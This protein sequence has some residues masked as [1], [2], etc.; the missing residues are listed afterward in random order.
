MLSP[1]AIL[2]EHYRIS[3]V[4]EERADSVIYRAI[5][6]RESFR[7]LIAALPHTNQAAIADAR[8]LATHIADVFAP[9]LLTLRDHFAQDLTYYLICD[10]PGGQDLERFLQ[11][12][13]SPLL[14]GAVLNQIE[15]LLQVLEHIHDRTPALLLG[16]LRPTDLWASP[17]GDLS[18]APFAL[19]R[20]VG[21]E[22]S[23]FRAP[24]LLDP[25]TEPTTSSDL[26]ALGAVMYR[27]LTGWAPPH[28]D[29]RQSGTP[30]TT[31]RSLNPKVSA[32]AEQLLLRVL[33]I[34]PTNRYQRAREMR[35]A[36]ETVRLMAGRPLGATAPV[37]SQASVAAALPATQPAAGTIEPANPNVLAGPPA[38]APPQPPVATATAP[39]GAT[40]PTQS[41]AP[42]SNGCLIAIVAMLAVV[43]ILICIAG[44]YVGLLI[45]NQAG[46]PLFGSAPA[47]T[48]GPA[49]PA[50]G[51]AVAPAD[52]NPPVPGTDL[53]TTFTQTA[54]IIEES[55]GATSYAPNGELL[56]VVLGSTIQL[57]DGATLDP[58]ETLRGHTGEISALAFSADSS[59]L[60]SGELDNSE[61]R[62][63]DVA[64]AS[65]VRML[66]GHSGWIRSL[67]FSNQGLLLASGS[68]DQ[69][70]RIWDVQSGQLLVVLEG[71]TD[72]IGNVAFSP[73]DE[74]LLSVARDGTARMWRTTDGEPVDTFRFVTPEDPNRDAPYWLT[75]AA[76]HP[77]GEIVAVGSTNGSVYLLDAATGSEQQ[78]LTGHTGWIVI[79]GVAFNSDGETLAS[80]GLD[81]AVRVWDPR[82]GTLLAVLERR[83]LRLI[84]LSWHPDGRRVAV[85][86]DTSGSVTVWDIPQETVLQSLQLAQGAV[87]ALTYS[88]TGEVLGSGGAGG[89]VRL[90]ALEGDR[91][92]TLSGGA[93][94][95]GYIG[96]LNN[97]ELISVSDTGAVL[98]I[99]LT[100][101]TETQP[102]TGLN[103]FALTLA[104]SQ[105]RSL[106]AAGN[107]RGDIALWETRDFELIRVLRGLDGPV[108]ALDA[109]P[110]GTRVAAV[111]NRTD[112]TSLVG[113]WDVATG[114]L[115]T[116]FD[117]HRGQ[118]T[119][120]AVPG[121]TD[122]V[123]SASSDG[124]MYIWDA[125]NGGIVHTIT[126][127]PDEGWFNAL[128]VSPD[129]TLLITG[130]LSGHLSFFDIQSGERLHR[131]ELEA[132]TILAL[133]IGPDGRH[134]AAST[135]DGGIF[136]FEAGS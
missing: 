49:Q 93:P 15:R 26:Y 31:P 81:G 10:D 115:Q 103:S 134:I 14:E 2:H 41:G 95:T 71:H 131:I 7:V 34:K 86:S 65:M 90:Q 80:V 118:I 72:Y 9:G 51:A 105:D 48:A 125:L 107:E 75:G 67:A 5:D 83:R 44:L 8:T 102:L 22:P 25:R 52:G 53:A 88:N 104:V 36:L 121:N 29:Q 128:A 85:S 54:Q 62:V 111:A 47:T 63:W 61:I 112:A 133:S 28:A 50:P 126:A 19:V 100:G 70:V 38:P 130:S 97:N 73:D 74:R 101:R 68:T 109:N 59:L 106:I 96:L 12:H 18:L 99:D 69:T 37:E 45:T 3:S 82:T 30:L 60:A 56:A 92:I 114:E 23:P 35:S 89:T 55:V 127:D 42:I 123:V 91:E 24:E 84:D 110:D 43:A 1:D 20:H 117:Q 108:F 27:L 33:E 4:V 119:D 40:R 13:G 6:Q 79:R 116:L 39:V 132:G 98:R 64:D 57:R 66:E 78:Q 11:D 21:S 17:E 87:T 122:L 58:R 76:F 94:S 16:D 120:V 46:L 129:G 124:R 32:L 113:V 136:L 135:R 77:S